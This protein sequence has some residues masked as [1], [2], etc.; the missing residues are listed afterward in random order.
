MSEAV[1]EAVSAAAGRAVSDSLDFSFSDDQLALRALVDRILDDLVTPDRLREVERGDEWFDRQ[2]WGA[3][4]DAGLLAVGLREAAGGSGGD[5]LDLALVIESIGRHVAPVPVVASVLTGAWPIAAFGDDTQRRRWVEPALA[6]AVVLGAALQEPGNDD[7]AHPVTNADLGVG[8]SGGAWRVNGVK[9]CVPVAHLAERLLVPARTGVGVG[10]FLVDPR[11]PSVTLV[12]S[13]ATNGEP[14]HEVSLRDTPGEALGDPAA[15][16]TI[17]R[18]IVAHATVAACLQQVGVSEQA[19]HLTAR[20]VTTREQF[21]QV[22]A[23][24]QAVSQRA[25]DAYIDTEAIRLTAWQAI[26]RLSEGLPATAEV[27]VAK[28]WA[29]EGGQRVVHAAQHLHGGMGVDKD[30]PLHRYFLLAK[31]LELTLGGAT[32]QLLKLGAI[33]ATEPV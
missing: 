20:H 17:A 13:V 24:F 10:V 23:S 14:L 27:A 6:G 5:F 11:D 33:L 1:S 16:T 25:A 29:A 9:Y 8:T 15:G 12:R 28:F 31:K 21:G 22:L 3:L 18:S 32:P 7:P 30:Y 26:W 2:A 19:L 4:A